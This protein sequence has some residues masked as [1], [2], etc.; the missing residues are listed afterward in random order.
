MSFYFSSVEVTR[1][2]LKKLIEAA[3]SYSIQY[4]KWSNLFS[5][6][7]VNIN[8]MRRTI[9]NFSENMYPLIFDVIWNVIFGMLA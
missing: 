5:L 3:V 1:L 2:W 8:Q 6:S 7:A 4:R 9:Q